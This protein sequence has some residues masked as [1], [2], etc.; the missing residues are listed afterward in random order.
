M[1]AV[2]KAAPIAAQ[3]FGTSIRLLRNIALWKDVLA[4]PVLEELALDELLSSKILPHLRTLLTTLHDAV[5]R[6]ERVFAA[7]SGVWVGSNREL[8]YVELA[9]RNLFGCLIT[10]FV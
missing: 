4:L 3:K 6:T 8:R 9:M 2:P 5:T 7:L 10:T 1:T